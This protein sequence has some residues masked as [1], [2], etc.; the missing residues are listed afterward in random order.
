MKMP[1]RGRALFIA[2]AAPLVFVLAF[3]V[4]VVAYA[5]F[6]MPPEV[7]MMTTGFTPQSIEIPE[8]EAIH[9]VNRSSTIT[10]ILCVGSDMRCDRPGLISPLL[11]PAPRSLQSPGASIAPQQ[12]KDVVFDTEGTFHITSAVVPGMNLTVTVDAGA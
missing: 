12:A 9:F 6:H 3:A 1:R 10:Q 7:D 11:V 5:H 4:V 8:G 2:I